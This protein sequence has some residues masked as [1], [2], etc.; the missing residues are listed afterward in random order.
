MTKQELIRAA[1]AAR[2]RAYAPYTHFKV[3]AA[4]EADTG[5]MENIGA[6]RAFFTEDDCFAALNSG[7]CD[8]VIVTSLYADYCIN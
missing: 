7:M 5:L 1:F 3:G 8:A 6:V 2:E 4:L